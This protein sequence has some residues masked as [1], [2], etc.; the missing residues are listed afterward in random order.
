M[1]L[2]QNV[3]GKSLY[4]L[5]TVQLEKINNATNEKLNENLSNNVFFF[6]LLLRIFDVVEQRRLCKAS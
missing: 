6:N 2:K 5:L 4:K 3:A 1:L